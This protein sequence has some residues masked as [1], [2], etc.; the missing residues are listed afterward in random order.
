[1]VITHIGRSKVI[2]WI[3]WGVSQPFL[4]FK[5]FLCLVVHSFIQLQEVKHI[6]NTR[7]AGKEGFWEMVEGWNEE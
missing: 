3:G 4:A 1:M 6:A 2:F 5:L 7:K